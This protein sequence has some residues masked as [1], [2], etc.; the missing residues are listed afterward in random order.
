MIEI[1]QG[2]PWNRRRW[3]NKQKFSG[4]PGCSAL[5]AMTSEKLGCWDFDDPVDGYVQQKRGGLPSSVRN[6]LMRLYPGNLESA[7]LVK[8]VFSP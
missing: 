6:R 3:V 7:S 4:V 5:Y 1:E 2:Q 8:P